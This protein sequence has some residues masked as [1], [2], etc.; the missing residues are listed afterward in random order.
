MLGITSIV[1]VL[2]LFLNGALLGSKEMYPCGLP[3]KPQVFGIS[4]NDSGEVLDLDL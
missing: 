3:H 2:R 1:V 4:M